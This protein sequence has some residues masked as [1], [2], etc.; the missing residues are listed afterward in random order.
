[1]SEYQYYEFQAVDQPLNDKEMN[2]LRSSSTRAEIT[3]HSLLM[4]TPGEAL[5]GMKTVGWKNISM[6]SSITPIGALTF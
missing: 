6:G 5:K 1:M 3:P 2:E 4:I